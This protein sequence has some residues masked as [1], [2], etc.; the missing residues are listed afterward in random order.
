MV[1]LSKAHPLIFNHWHVC[2]CVHVAKSVDK[3]IVLQLDPVLTQVQ[4]NWKV[5]T[6]A[7]D[8]CTWILSILLHLKNTIAI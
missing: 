2:V 1:E 7:D 6:A 3:M 8:C 5:G 4:Q